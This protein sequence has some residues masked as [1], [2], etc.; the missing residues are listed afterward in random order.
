M[1]TI[2]KLEEQLNDFSIATR[3]EAITELESRNL[4]HQRKRGTPAM[5]WH[6]FLS[7]N[8]KI[9]SP[10]RLFWEAKK[11]GVH[12]VGSIEFDVLDEIEQRF[13]VGD[14]LGL[15]VDI[16]LETRVFCPEYYEKELVMN[17]PGEPGISYAMGMSFT[18]FPFTESTTD[19]LKGL[20]ESA[21][22]RNL[23][24]MGDVNKYLEEPG[25]I[26][27]S[28]HV[29]PLTPYRNATERHM[30]AAYDTKVE[31][32][33]K[34][35]GQNWKE[36]VIHYWDNKLGADVKVREIID[37]KALFH[38]AIRKRLMKKGG[39]GYVQPD[40][41]TFPDVREFFAWVIECGGI[42]MAT[43]LDGTTNGEANPR[44]LLEYYKS[45]GA[46]ALNIIP[47]R[48]ANAEK[49]GNL[50]AIIKAAKEL[51]M[52]LC[53]GTEMNSPGQP[54][55]DNWFGNYLKVYRQDA[56]KGAQHFHNHTVTKRTA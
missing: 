1:V 5:H 39:V 22:K 31:K 42:P 43:W 46:V 19:F 9:W 28:E 56:L 52:P 44:E 50:Q 4:C 36:E 17:S 10:E 14:L 41:T 7:Y 47:H 24:V 55:L 34:E 16:G 3:W 40:K 33:F 25:A 32:Y 12:N 6:S 35:K 15:A 53:M 30:V 23:R 20:R 21:K 18:S 2:T 37:N 45:T 27:Y 13:K 54:F 11:K 51:N 29:L 8:F 38:G 49:Y 26:D 48:T